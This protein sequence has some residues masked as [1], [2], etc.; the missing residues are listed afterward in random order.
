[1]QSLSEPVPA[2][3]SIRPAANY[4]F[5]NWIRLVAIF[6]IVYEH[7][8]AIPVNVESQVQTFNLLS[9]PFKFGTIC[10]FM[11]SGYLLGRKLS[12]SASPWPYYRRR[13]MV[14]GL[15]FTIAFGLY[16]LKM[17]GV[18]GRVLGRSM[19]TDL[20]GT[21]LIDQL[22]TNLF[23]TSYW[24]MVSFLLALG[25]LL[26]IWR[27][28]D[29]PIVGWI[30]FGVTCLFAVNVYANWFS[31]WH[32]LAMPAYVFYL[33]LGVW[34]A[35]HEKFMQRLQAWN[36]PVLTAALLVT[37]GLAYLETE[38][39]VRYGSVSPINTLRPT[40]QL[41]SVIAFVWLVRYDGLHRFT[42]WLNPRSESFG[43]YL[44]HMFFVGLLARLIEYLPVL[45]G[46][47]DYPPLNYGLGDFVVMNIG[48]VG[49]I[50]VATLCFVKL[51]N[52][53]PL[54]WLFGER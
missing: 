17:I 54:R 45:R 53:T 33:W 12:L 38:L 11:I 51:I 36:R 8:I 23:F 21:F 7:S 32:T 9:Q 41:F 30:S 44:Y 16:Y 28:V 19:D 20:T 35:R 2:K 42:H 50:Y 48:R 37:M 14:V 22:W 40:N 27:Q 18:V 3:G 52:R 49:L 31:P 1:M 39:L 29:R 26:L 34:L 13:L 10:F 25:V 4:N 46:L 43:L 24:F 47:S 15:P 5:V 6:S